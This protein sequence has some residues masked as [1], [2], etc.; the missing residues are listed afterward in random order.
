MASGTYWV[1]RRSCAGRTKTSA[2]IVAALVFCAVLSAG[3]EDNEDAVLC[4]GDATCGGGV[5]LVAPVSQ[6]QYCA[7]PSAG[8]ATHHRWASTAGDELAGL[9]VASEAP[10]DAG[11]AP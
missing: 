6:L 3:C 2:P 10:S 9:C 4:T 7:D 11:V 5:C 1:A 8:C